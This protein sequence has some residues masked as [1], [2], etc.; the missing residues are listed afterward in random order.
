[1]NAVSF[2]VAVTVAVTVH[3]M[4]LR[5]R[6]VQC[7]VTINCVVIVIIIALGGAVHSLGKRGYEIIFA[8]AHCRANTAHH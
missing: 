8:S 6:Q 4:T 7:A 1:V 2:L 5:Q 3:S